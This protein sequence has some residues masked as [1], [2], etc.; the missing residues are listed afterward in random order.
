MCEGEGDGFGPIRDA[1]F[2][3]YV[4]DMELRSRPVD[5][6][7]FRDARVVEPLCHERKHLALAGSEIVARSGRPR[8]DVD[9][10]L[11][12]FRGEGRPTDAC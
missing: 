2:G 8:G 7:A 10:C 11:R 4:A 3:E 6:K 12:R 5:H 9:Q 1:E